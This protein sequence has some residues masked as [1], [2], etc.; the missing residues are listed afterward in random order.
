MFSAKC[1]KVY[2]LCYLIYFLVWYLFSR[3]YVPYSWQKWLVLLLLLSTHS[4]CYPYLQ[5]TGASAPPASIKQ[6]SPS[7]M[8]K[9]LEH[10]SSQER[11]EHVKVCRVQQQR[12]FQ[13]TSILLLVVITSLAWEEDT[14]YESHQHPCSSLEHEGGITKNFVLHDYYCTM[15]HHSPPSTLSVHCLLLCL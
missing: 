9:L 10:S 14:L 13:A 12:R 7:T 8:K 11:L 6:V 4:I 2:Q 3:L 15:N 1:V 5:E